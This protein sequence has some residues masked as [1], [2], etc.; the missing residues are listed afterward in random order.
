MLVVAI[1]GILAAIAVPAYRVNMAETESVD[2]V[3]DIKEIGLAIDK[4]FSE[5]G[6]Y[7]DTLAE[8]GK[9]G[10]R[11]PWDRPYVYMNMAN[12]PKQNRCRTLRNTHPLN[13]DYDLYSMGQDGKSNR[14]INAKPSWD[15]IVRAYNGK[16]IGH[17][18]DI[19]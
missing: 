18:E 6:R 5:N 19:I 4:F 12:D 8:I 17:A 7:P 9:D 15:D 11:D 10:L 3:S 16:Y 14:P 1:V 2:A 13:L